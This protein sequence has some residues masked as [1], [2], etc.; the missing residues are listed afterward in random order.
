M[1]KPKL[2]CVVADGSD[3]SS[4]LVLLD[5]RLLDESQRESP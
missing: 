1:S 2:K 4:R 3:D 5:E